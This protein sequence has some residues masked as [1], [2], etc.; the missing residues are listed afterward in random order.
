MALQHF[1]TKA[2]QQKNQANSFLSYSGKK[3]E[4]RWGLANFDDLVMSA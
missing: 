1:Q 2:G 3:C 4:R